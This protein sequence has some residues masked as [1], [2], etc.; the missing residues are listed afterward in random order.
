MAPTSAATALD[1]T[2]ITRLFRRCLRSAHQIESA[3][4]RETYLIYVRDGFR[5]K[6]DLPRNSRE[7]VLAYQ[8]GLDQVEQMEYYQH[9]AKMKFDPAGQN[10]EF[11]P[12]L[13]VS[14]TA[15]RPSLGSLGGVN[16]NVSIARW[17]NIKN[18]SSI[19]QNIS[20][21]L[22]TNLPHLHTDD[23]KEY[24]QCLIDDGFDSEE[25]I[26]EE[27]REDDLNFMKKAHRRALM[28]KIL[29]RRV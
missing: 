6:A 15:F 24:T 18:H 16:N 21:W 12:T 2:S 26:L 19:E 7:A 10:I 28:R 20:Q 8:D 11:N 4:Q 17:E 5:R 14:S 13:S 25:F 27:L 29:E 1:K 3:S 22:V 23:V 9:M